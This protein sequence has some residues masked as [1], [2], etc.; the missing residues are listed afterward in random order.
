MTVLAV[1]CM[2]L[3]VVAV[4]AGTVPL[5]LGI[6]A[7][8]FLLVLMVAGINNT[9]L[10][11]LCLAFATAPAYK[12][13]ASSPGAVITPTDVFLV[14]GLVLLAPTLL[15]S[16]FRVPT[17]YQIGLLVIVLPAI[18]SSA[19][20]TS[21]IRS[22]FDVLQLAFVI[23]IL[24]LV[25][26]TFAGSEKIINLLAWS[27]VAGHCAS[28]LYGIAHGPVYGNRYQGLTHHPNAFS[29]AGL[30]SF[31][32]LLYLYN[33]RPGRLYRVVALGAMFLSVA[34]VLMSGSRAATVVVGVLILMI[35]VVE[36]SAVST[37]LVS[38]LVAVGV[39]AI[40]FL[41]ESGT[42]GS[43]LERLT[44]TADAVFADNARNN[45]LVAGWTRFLAHPVI[46]SGFEG[47]E[48]MHN[49]F[50][51]VAVATGVIGLMGYLLVVYV[52]ARPLFGTNELRRL[53]YV[54]WAFI[55][56]VPTVPGLE[57][58]TLC[59]PFAL[60]IVVAVRELH[61]RS[62]SGGP[63]RAR[64]WADLGRSVAVRGEVV[65]SGA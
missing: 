30:M 15:V 18:V 32:L 37:F 10:M 5:V 35:P 21:F 65:G 25:F 51:E 31:A 24:P 20:T 7:V 2:L 23:A 44:G 22:F 54:A 3:A 36:R 16:S 4:V 53:A 42:G 64:D 58:R 28:A 26:A 9:A 14:I 41:I 46:G 12:G 61:E 34:S 62:G 63:D 6:A 60:A 13:L 39:I 43:A 1:P 19:L 27:Y 33:R 57:D 29:E 50:L 52:F 17:T 40:P 45:E 38:A 49:V 8:G 11:V 55:G 48:L 47:V 56:L 59:V